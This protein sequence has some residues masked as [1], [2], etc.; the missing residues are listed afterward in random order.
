MAEPQ[1]PEFF[2][3]TGLHV[4]PIATNEELWAIGLV[5]SLWTLVEHDITV[6]GDVLTSYD[7]AAKSEFHATVSLRPRI[8]KV[9]E[10]IYRNAAPEHRDQWL[11]LINRA[12]S[13]QLQRDRIIHG[14]WSLVQ[15][16][17]G[18]IKGP[19][20]LR[21]QMPHRASFKWNLTYETI[22]KT[23]QAID[24]LIFD[25]F[26]FKIEFWDLKEPSF[27]PSLRQRLLKP[28]PRP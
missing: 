16:K 12:G 9:R 6:F 15:L 20:H 17:S 11:D 8:A 26:L 13:M 27:A 4:E 25:G 28:G 14:T 23:A 19:P 21:N 2:I 10:L 7:A 1:P 5:A 24:K 3:K 18:E 22:F